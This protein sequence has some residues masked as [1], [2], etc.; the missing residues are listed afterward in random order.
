MA[1]T[2][3]LLLALLGAAPCHTSAAVSFELARPGTASAGLFRSTDGSLVRHVFSGR[4]LAAGVHTVELDEGA[5]ARAAGDEPLELRVVSSSGV[6][7]DWQGVI[8][9]TG[10][11]NGPGA[12][13][14]RG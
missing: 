5:V 4:V 2:L 3:M 6:A 9:N 10:P 8:G 13:K 14:V 12:L 11:L 1:H 7:Y